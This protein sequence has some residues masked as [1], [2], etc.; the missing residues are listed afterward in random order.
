LESAAAPAPLSK[1]VASALAAPPK[2]PRPAARKRKAPPVPEVPSSEPAVADS[3][4]GTKSPTGEPNPYDVKLEDEPQPVKPSV[5]SS[6]TDD[7]PRS[8]ASASKSPGF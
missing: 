2:A 5:P 7:T 4:S 1:A 6:A 8:G 3:P